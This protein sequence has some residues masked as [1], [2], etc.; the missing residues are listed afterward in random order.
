MEKIS[1]INI[2]RISLSGFRNQKEP[3]SFTL[4][5]VT[6]VTGHNGSGKT[7]LREQFL[8]GQVRFYRSIGYPSFAYP[9]KSGRQNRAYIR[10]L[11][12]KAGGN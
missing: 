2:C 5:D 9:P 12:R 3:V 6:C 7:T 1:E 4:G 11:Y 8:R 10:L